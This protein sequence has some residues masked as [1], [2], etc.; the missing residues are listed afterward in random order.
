MERAR[1]LQQFSVSIVRILNKYGGGVRAGKAIMEII[2][3][4]CGQCRL[5]IK[6]I[7]DDERADLKRDLYEIGFFDEL[8]KV[9][10]K[11]I[12]KEKEEDAFPQFPSSC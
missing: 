11:K 4:N 3:I 7:T 2:G 6:E 10:Y 9:I 8:E 12:Y 1:E 5:P